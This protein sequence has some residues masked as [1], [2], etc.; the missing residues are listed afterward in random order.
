VNQELRELQDEVWAIKGV[1]ED[2]EPRKISKPDS[3][4]LAS[5]KRDLERSKQ[6]LVAMRDKRKRTTDDEPE[7]TNESSS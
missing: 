1:C 4:T 3:V 7:T 2:L 6:R 5:V